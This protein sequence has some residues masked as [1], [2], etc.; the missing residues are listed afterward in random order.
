LRLPFARLAFAL[1]A[2]IAV[3]A[4]VACGGDDSD[5]GDT[6][7]ER[8]VRQLFEQQL[9]LFR[10]GDFDAL[11]ANYSQDF[12]AQ[13]SQDDL[14]ESITAAGLIA[15]RLSFEDVRVAVDGDRANVTYTTVYDGDPTGQVE[16]DSPDVY[17]RSGG[18]WYDELDAH[19]HC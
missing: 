10:A 2:G 15:D 16:E 4:G 1:T 9:A 11:Y 7:D 18:R 3:A 8:A 13:C 5:S 14:V 17:T 6:D 12:R 19:T